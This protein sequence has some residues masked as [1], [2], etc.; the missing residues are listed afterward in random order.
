ALQWFAV[1]F[2][3]FALTRVASSF[4]IGPLIDRFGS[5]ALF[6]FHL[7]PLCAGIALLIVVTPEWVVP[8]YWVFAG[9]SAGAAGT[10]QAALVAEHVPPNRLGAARGILASMMV[11]ASAAG[12][13]MYGW[14]LAAG[15]SI[16]AILWGTTVAMLGATVLGAAARPRR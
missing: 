1:S 5:T 6:A 3:A 13:A 14:L 7:L 10:L 16:V 12:P 11:L 15:V 9:M 8:V 4:L 2:F